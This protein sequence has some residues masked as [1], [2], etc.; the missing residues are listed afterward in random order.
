[1][2]WSV[3]PQLS[4]VGHCCHLPGNRET[5]LTLEEHTRETRRKKEGQ[6]KKQRKLLLIAIRTATNYMYYLALKFDF[7]FSL[8]SIN[9]TPDNDYVDI[10]LS[11]LSS[12]VLHSFSV[13]MLSFFRMLTFYSFLS[14][15]FSLRWAYTKN[16]YY[17]NTIFI[18]LV[19]SVSFLFS[20]FCS[21]L[22]Y[23]FFC[24][25]SLFK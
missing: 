3:Q 12:C 7:F 6:K 17:T 11:V 20:F 13:I 10:F 23:L 9:A 19:L 1:M 24:F 5:G 4:L 18:M 21:F 2:K 14:F 25:L 22:I 8:R 16:V 15:F